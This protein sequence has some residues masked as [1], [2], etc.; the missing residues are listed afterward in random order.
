VRIFTEHAWGL[1]KACDTPSPSDDAGASSPGKK[2]KG[3]GKKDPFSQIS[4]YGPFAPLPSTVDVIYDPAGVDGKAAKDREG[5][6]KGIHVTD[7]KFRNGHLEKW[8]RCEREGLICGICR[9]PI[10]AQVRPN[11]SHLSSV[12]LTL[13]TKNHIT[14]ALCPSEPIPVTDTGPQSSSKECTATFHL[15]CLATHFLSDEPTPTSTASATTSTSATTLPAPA[16]AIL[17]KTGSCP[18]CQAPQEWGTV[19]RG[20]YAR[21]DAVIDE[22]ARLQK[23]AVKEARKRE[24]AEKGKSGTQPAEE[25]DEEEDED[26]AFIRNMED[27]DEPSNDSATESDAEPPVP[28]PLPKGRKT[29]AKPRE[30]P[31][32]RRGRAPA[33]G[34]TTTSRAPKGTKATKATRATKKGKDEEAGSGSESEG[35]KLE[36]EMMALNDSE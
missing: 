1:W 2:K 11:H 13:D 35:T 22:R 15:P 32:T 9:D 26:E 18:A 33:T 17:P 34:K 12:V 14:F 27:D 6:P 4:R 28:S 8:Q 20:C 10:D 30:K 16:R 3:R 36:R 29:A 23:E 25:E 5:K 31:V 7:G 21:R 24:R 19:I